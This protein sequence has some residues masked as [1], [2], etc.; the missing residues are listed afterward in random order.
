MNIK[1]L[2]K[3]SANDTKYFKANVSIL[4]FLLR[5]MILLDKANM[6]KSKANMSNNIRQI[7]H[8]QVIH[9]H[10]RGVGHHEHLK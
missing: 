1:D 2:N 6:S 9:S 3:K 10:Q 7:C 4:N 5:Q 8:R